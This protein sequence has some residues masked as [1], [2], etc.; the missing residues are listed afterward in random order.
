MMLSLEAHP[1]VLRKLPLRK[2]KYM[3][4]QRY[5][6]GLCVL[7]AAT[8]F[9]GS[10]LACGQD[11]A[12]NTAVTLSPDRSTS[13]SSTRALPEAPS[14]LAP[15]GDGDT[16]IQDVPHS[17]AAVLNTP[18]HILLDLGH[19][20]ISPS[21]IRTR[22]LKWLLPLTVAT[23]AAFATD[24]HTM[25]RVVS[26]NP[27][28]NDTAINVSD[29]LRDG[30]IAVPAGLFLMGHLTHSEHSKETGILAGEAVIDANILA[31]VVKLV[32]YRERPNVDSAQGEFFVGKSGPNGSFISGHAVTAWSSAA[33]LAAEYKSPWAQAGIYSLAT[34]VSL[35]RVLGQQHFP[36]DVLIGSATGWLIGHY[37]Y[38]AHRHWHV[39]VH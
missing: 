34:G 39:P 2:Q 10:T 8:L 18:K 17:E 12:D 25:R 5:R 16:P 1:I 19:I 35:T 14:A 36:S 38:R 13:A 15:R 33:V 29:G 4:M 27:S 23:G 31:Q 3:F 32:S 37:V 28:F 7:T 22:D 24:T 11:I 9:S 30:F 21:Y 6:L 26:Q 20:A